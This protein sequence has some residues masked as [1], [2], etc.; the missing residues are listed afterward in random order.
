VVIP[1][2]A[3]KADLTD[4]KDSEK[5]V[6]D[7]LYGILDG[8]YANLVFEG[9]EYRGVIGGQNVRIASNEFEMLFPSLGITP[10]FLKYTSDHSLKRAN[11]KPKEYNTPSE[12]QTLG[13]PQ[14]TI[15]PD[16]WQC[17]FCTLINVLP[18]YYCSACSKKNFLAYDDYS[19]NT[20]RFD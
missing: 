12:A 18:D 4:N 19:I 9:E 20:K 13:D 14:A 1:V 2:A 11:T 17:E 16:E 7:E 15:A 10:Y 6:L 8:E 5:Y 3:D